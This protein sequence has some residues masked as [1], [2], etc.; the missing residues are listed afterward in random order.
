MALLNKAWREGEF[1]P[2]KSE[3]GL[4]KGF[5]WRDA[6]EART[7]EQI[8]R[9]RFAYPSAEDPGLKTYTNL[10]ERS[11]AVRDGSGATVFPDI[12]V[13]DV[14]TTEARLL[15]EVETARSLEEEPDLAEKWQAFA[16]VGPLYLFVPMS[17][18]SA[19]RS[20]I[21]QAKASLAGLRTWRY[22]AGMDFT[23]VMEVP[24]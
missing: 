20:R 14:K 8:A 12:V 10:P 2:P 3:P 22:M 16:S 5:P 23:E 24:L 13:F 1:V 18:L 15:G 17:Q 11:L 21:R 9:Q 19:A 4:T 6:V 7:V